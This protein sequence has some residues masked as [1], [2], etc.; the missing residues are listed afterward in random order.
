MAQRGEQR[1]DVPSTAANLTIRLRPVGEIS[2]GVPR[3]SA[4]QL[5]HAVTLAMAMGGP[6]WTL[7]A[8]TT[9]GVPVWLVSALAFV[10]VC[11]GVAVLCMPRRA[12]SCIKASRDAEG[13]RPRRSKN[14]AT[15]P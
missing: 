1:P 12:P 8:G 3:E 11:G 6:G 9:A 7:W 10:Q 15:R 13:E 4:P 14:R 5:L 2:I